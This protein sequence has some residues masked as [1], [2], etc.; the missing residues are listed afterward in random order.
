MTENRLEQAIKEMRKLGD[1]HEFSPGFNERVLAALEPELAKLRAGSEAGIAEPQELPGFQRPGSASP[2][3]VRSFSA[4]AVLAVA[5]SVCV[6]FAGV[7]SKRQGAARRGDS[8]TLSPSITGEAMAAFEALSRLL[9]EHNIHMPAKQLLDLYPPI[10]A[11]TRSAATREL[12][13]QIWH[14]AKLFGYEVVSW[15]D[16][17]STPF[18]TALG[19]LGERRSDNEREAV[20]ILRPPGHAAPAASFIQQDN[21]RGTDEERPREER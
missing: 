17:T 12:R 15:S 10:E 16:G 21:R 5:V 1:E 9:A 14:C 3:I 13:R 11:S 20:Q 4:A 18:P 2:L 8:T 7:M 19:V 6:M